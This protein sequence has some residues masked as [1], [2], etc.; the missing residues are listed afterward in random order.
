M[1]VKCPT[2]IGFR[3]RLT[4]EECGLT[5][6]TLEN[7]C[8]GVSN[9]LISQIETGHIRN[10]GVATIF[11]IAAALGV[12]PGWLAWGE[13]PRTEAESPWQNSEGRLVVGE[14]K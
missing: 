2:A 8:K 9:A 1:R 11:E 7:R 3:L 4:R 6:R 14:T 10:P 12:R 5:L 13:L